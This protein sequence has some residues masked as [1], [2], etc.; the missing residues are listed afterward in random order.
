MEG[1]TPPHDGGLV[2]PGLIKMELHKICNT[3]FAIFNKE[4]IITT[5][6]R[7]FTYVTV[8]IFYLLNLFDYLNEYSVTHQIH[9]HFLLFLCVLLLLML[10]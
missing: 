7:D 8:M 9:S 5:N 2:T 4:M 3:L 6:E 1:S 10:N